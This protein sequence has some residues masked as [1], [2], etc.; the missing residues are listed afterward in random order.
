MAK[1][2]HFTCGFRA[3]WMSHAG[4]QRIWVYYRLARLRINYFPS[5]NLYEKS[6]R[7]DDQLWSCVDVS[8]SQ[9]T[10]IEQTC[11]FKG[12][13]HQGY[14]QNYQTQSNKEYLH[15]KQHITR[16][17]RPFNTFRDICLENKYNCVGVVKCVQNDSAKYVK[18]WFIKSL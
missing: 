12:N 17:Y 3:A 11:W 15:I 7:L 14:W 10:D 4:V 2:C 6:M 9:R 16:I 1:F 5:G 18:S 13:I 8:T